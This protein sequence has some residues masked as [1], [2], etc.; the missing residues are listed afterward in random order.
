MLKNHLLLGIFNSLKFRPYI[1][2]IYGIYG[3]GTSNQSVPEM[4]ID[5]RCVKCR[6]DQ[7]CTFFVYCFAIFQT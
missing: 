6:F 4:A 1:G 2:L 5:L 3:I 7:Q